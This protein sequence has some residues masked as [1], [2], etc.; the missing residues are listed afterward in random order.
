M[1]K[2]NYQDDNSDILVDMKIP[3]K[4]LEK[5]IDEAAKGKTHIIFNP[6]DVKQIE[7]AGLPIKKTFILY[8]DYLE[9]MFSKKKENALS[10]IRKIPK[11][12]DKIANGVVTEI[13]GEIRDSLALGIFTA[14]IINSI[15]LL[16]YSLRHRLYRKMKDKQ[17]DY[18][19]SNME[20]MLF[21]NLINRLFKEKI[22]SANDKIDLLSFNDK[23]RNPYFHLNIHK[24]SEGAF[25]PEIESVNINTGEKT[26][27]KN[28][29]VQD[30]EF[31]WFAAKRKFDDFFVYCI[32]DY[33][34]KWTNKL[35]LF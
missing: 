6:D 26:V 33:C 10:L 21:K 16:E 34:I 9:K 35:M 20:K 14:T 13:Y 24:L 22:L 27:I 15:L 8:E 1:I 19:W 17:K 4:Q 23:Y 12:D 28:A 11:L 30:Y 31:L 25:F 3:S 2:R 7:E 5:I 29:K 18:S 32:M